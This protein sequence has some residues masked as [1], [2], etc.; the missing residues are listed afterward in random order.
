M[1]FDKTLHFGFIVMNVSNSDSMNVSLVVA[2]L[3][4]I[5][6]KYLLTFNVLGLAS[7]K[8]TPWAPVAMGSTM[9]TNGTSD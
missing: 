3:L 5:Y 7:C 2:S 4:Q 1:N 8:L 9:K 6:Y